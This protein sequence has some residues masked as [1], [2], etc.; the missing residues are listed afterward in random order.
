[1]TE[2]KVLD[3]GFVKLVRFMGDDSAI[4]QSARVSYGEGTKTY[5]EDRGLIRYLMKNEHTSPFE[6]VVFVFHMK[7]P[8]FVTRQ[9][10]RHRTSRINEVSG[11][12]SELPEEFY[13]P[14]VININK[15]SSNNKQGRGDIFNENDAKRIATGM[16]IMSEDSFDYYHELLKEDV[17]REIARIQLPTSTYTEW[18]WQMDL[19]NLFHFLK[20]RMDP[21][22]QWETQQY[23]VAIYELIKP[24]VPIACEAFEDYML[25]AKTFSAQEMEMLI[26]L[27]KNIT[28]DGFSAELISKLSKRELAEFKSKLNME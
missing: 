1:M 18:Y 9:I 28:L 21:H 11:R 4:V 16:K 12:Y 8:I 6:Q 17:A 26:G 2:I 19:R 27:V 24:I 13:V 3:K 15:Q 10:V 14:D 25:N 23:A 7:L 22:A 5:R 20:L